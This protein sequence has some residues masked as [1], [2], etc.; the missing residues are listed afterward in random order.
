M[1]LRRNWRCG[2]KGLLSHSGVISLVVEF[3]VGSHDRNRDGRDGSERPPALDGKV[4]QQGVVQLAGSS[5]MEV[6]RLRRLARV[7]AF[8]GSSSGTSRCCSRSRS[9]RPP[10]ASHTVEA[11]TCRWLLHMRDL[12]GGDDL[13]LTQEFLAQML[14]VRRTS[15]TVVASPLRKAG[16]HRLHSRPHPPAGCRGTERGLRVLRHGQGPLSAASF[17]LRDRCL[18]TSM[19]A[20]GQKR[21]YAVQKG[22]SAFDPKRTSKS[23]TRLLV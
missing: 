8:R 23:Q 6:D 21:T 11:R 5:V 15:V 20:L 9:S 16:S 19:S 7:R 14:G 3:D 22:M 1:S 4:S 12:A 18:E 2:P 10:H 17:R 13:M